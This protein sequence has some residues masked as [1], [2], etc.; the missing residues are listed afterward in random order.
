MSTE[1][2]S[3]L[4]EKQAVMATLRCKQGQEDILKGAGSI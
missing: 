4:E 1:Y 3:L 2:S